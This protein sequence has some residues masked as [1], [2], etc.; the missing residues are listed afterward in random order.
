MPAHRLSGTLCQHRC[1]CQVAPCLRSLQ[2]F[3]AHSCANLALTA[4]SSL[5][6]LTFLDLS[7]S[8]QLTSTAGVRLAP[9]TIG[10]GVKTLRM[11]ASCTRA[12]VHARAMCDRQ[13]SSPASEG[14]WQHV[15]RS[16]QV[17]GLRN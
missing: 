7:H 3:T 15:S 17:C 2:A 13:R 5:V 1:V 16:Q 14:C 11:A 12:H 8:S 9:S 10:G 4:L 6:S